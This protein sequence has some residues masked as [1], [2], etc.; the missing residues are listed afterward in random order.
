MTEVPEPAA[1]SELTFF[2]LPGVQLP[3][4]AG[5]ALYYA[6]PPFT[7][8]TVIGAVT[9]DKPRYAHK[10]RSVFTYTPVLTGLC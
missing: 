5:V 10:G 8:W 6:L 1:V 4:G 3:P 2:L 7:E 9:A